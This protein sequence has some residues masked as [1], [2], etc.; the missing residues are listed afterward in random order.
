M[1]IRSQ[2]QSRYE[3]NHSLGAGKL[4]APT[5]EALFRYWSR[6][7]RHPYSIDLGQLEV[8]QVPARGYRDRIDCQDERSHG[9]DQVQNM[10]GVLH[11]HSTML[12]RGDKVIK[13]GFALGIS[14][15]YQYQHQQK[16]LNSTIL[17]P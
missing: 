6:S 8:C 16:S 15:E 3:L 11:S 10:A 5:K 1:H 17:G 13:Q 12:E 2:D 14:S 7:E 4:P 9:K